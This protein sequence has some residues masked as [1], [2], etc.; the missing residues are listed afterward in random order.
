MGQSKQT[1]LKVKLD[2]KLIKME[3]Q[4]LPMEKLAAGKFYQNSLAQGILG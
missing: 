2:G 1:I 3:M 4:S